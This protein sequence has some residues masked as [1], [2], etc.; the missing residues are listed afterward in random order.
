[1]QAGNPEFSNLINKS[2]SPVFLVDQFSGFNAEKDTYD[3]VHP[4]Q[5]GEQKIA[6]RWF[7]QLK[8]ILSL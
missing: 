7:N 4:N 8:N 6:D 5:S 3:G 1:L 2:D